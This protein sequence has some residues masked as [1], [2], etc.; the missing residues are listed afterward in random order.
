MVPNKTIIPIDNTDTKNNITI[1]DNIDT[2][3]DEILKIV[4]NCKTVLTSLLNLNNENIVEQEV[5]DKIKTF[6]ITHVTISWID[7]IFENDV[8]EFVVDE[9]WKI[10]FDK[11]I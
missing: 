8:V 1:T 7:T 9:I 3:L 2:K 10:I 5:K 4:T 11:L 6:L